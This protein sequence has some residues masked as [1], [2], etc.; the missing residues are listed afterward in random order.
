MRTLARYLLILEVVACYGPGLVVLAVG[1]LVTPMWVAML[2]ALAFNAKYREHTSL[3]E[4]GLIVGTILSVVGGVLGFIGLFR[5]LSSL[6]STTEELPYTGRTRT[7]VL[8]GVGTLIYIV[9]GQ[10]GAFTYG[11]TVRPWEHL[12]WQE[13]A[14][15]PALVV[16]VPPLLASGHIVYLARRRL[17]AHDHRSISNLG[18]EP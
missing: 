6:L 3:L 5:V 2:A 7:F 12:S 4:V 1:I 13:L 18:N 11:A 16:A 10:L 17:F 8:I 14:Q 15:A 9:T